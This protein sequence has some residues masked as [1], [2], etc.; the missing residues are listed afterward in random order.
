MMY[1]GD[2][3]GPDPFQKKTGAYQAKARPAAGLFRKAKKSGPALIRICVGNVSTENPA[4]WKTSAC[5]TP[6]PEHHPSFSIRAFS[7]HSRL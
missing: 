2:G 3:S 1:L 7:A 4:C 6:H 5:A